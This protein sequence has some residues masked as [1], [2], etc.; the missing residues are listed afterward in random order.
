MYWAGVRYRTR[1]VR[2]GDWKLFVPEGGAEPQLFDLAADPNEATD[3]AAK[4]PEKVAALKQ[5]LAKLAER[6]NE[7]KPTAGK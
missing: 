2:D 1:A 3:L 5:L 6:D 7:S 4:R